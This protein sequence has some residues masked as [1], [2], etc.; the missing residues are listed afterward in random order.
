MRTKRTARQVVARALS[1]VGQIEHPMGSNRTIYGKLYGMDGN[2]WCAMFIW[3]VINY[4]AIALI[5]KTAWTP[6]LADWAKK[7]GILRPANSAAKLGDI[8]LFQMPGPNR[9]NHVGLIVRNRAEGAP[10]YCVEGNTGGSNPRAGGMVAA[11]K[12]TQ[13]IKYIIDMS[14]IYAPEPK[15]AA[16]PKTAKYVLSR[17]LVQGS[18]GKAVEKLQSV[19]KV[20]VDGDFGPKTKAA[21]IKFQKSKKL[22]QDG[23]VGKN[24]CRALGWVWAG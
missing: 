22:V 20:T 13:Y 15:K 8:V 24:T 19:L 3:W 10:L 1:Q 18:S 9:V 23:Y 17:A 11:T 14:K 5:P 7:R 2:A 12:R 4:L 21:V 6:A 16:K